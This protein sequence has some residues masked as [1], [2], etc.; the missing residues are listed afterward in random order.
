MNEYL[1]GEEAVSDRRI[2]T[3]VSTIISA[4]RL[5]V[6]SRT[7][8]EALVEGIRRPEAERCFQ[9]L[10]QPTPDIESY[11]RDKTVFIPQAVSL[12]DRMEDAGFLEALRGAGVDGSSNIFLLPCGL[13]PVK[14][15]LFVVKVRPP[16][17]AQSS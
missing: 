8:F 17:Q 15:P 14:D 2:E 6:F 9:R 3:I 16:C 11:V 5:V 10:L 4:F 13:R 7:L 1:L 12:P